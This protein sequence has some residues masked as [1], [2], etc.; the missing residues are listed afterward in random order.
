M[1]IDTQKLVHALG[2]VD[3]E[4]AGL[5]PASGEVDTGTSEIPVRCQYHRERDAVLLQ[6]SLRQGVAFTTVAAMFLTDDPEPRLLAG[7]TT[8]MNSVENVRGSLDRGDIHEQYA[9]RTL[10]AYVLARH[11]RGSDQGFCEV[12]IPE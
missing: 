12:T 10:L 9:G 4:L 11:A 7:S 2:R 6:Y 3:P 8:R 1:K 5:L